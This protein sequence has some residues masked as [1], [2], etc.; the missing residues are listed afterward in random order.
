MTPMGARLT[1]A[2]KAAGFETA[3]AAAERLGVAPATY[4]QH[5]NGTRGYRSPTAAR[6]ARAFR[7]TPEWLLYGKKVE[8]GNATKRIPIIS[9]VSAGKIVDPDAAHDGAHIAMDGLP[10]GRYFCTRV[11][12]DSMDRLSPEGSIII[13]NA[14]DKDLQNGKAYIFSL[15]GEATYKRYFSNPVVRLEPYSTNPANQTIFPKADKDWSV[16]GRVVR[17]V[18]DLP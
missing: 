10:D 8:N 2:R 11:S 4:T 17:S 9:W 15:R 1:E 14:D 16:I 12:G 13:V 18:L 7:V 6:Y 3:K 5:E